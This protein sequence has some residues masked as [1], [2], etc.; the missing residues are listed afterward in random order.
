MGQDFALSHIQ[1]VLFINRRDTS[2]EGV[3]ERSY[4]FFVP[5]ILL[6]AVRSLYGYIKL[7][8]RNYPY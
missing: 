2:R 5:K 7:L 6:L 8:L 3:W 1:H 4:L